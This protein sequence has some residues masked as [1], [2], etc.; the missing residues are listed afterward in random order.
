MLFHLFFLPRKAKRV[1]SQ[2]A[3]Q[4]LSLIKDRIRAR[5]EWSQGEAISMDRKIETMGCLLLNGQSM[6]M[7]TVSMK[8]WTNIARQTRGVL[9]TL[10]S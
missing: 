1:S 6:T 4:A 8:T 10:C 2:A 3:L 9:R 5:R 7:R